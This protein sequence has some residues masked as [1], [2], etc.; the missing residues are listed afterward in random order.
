MLQAF[1]K[2]NDGN[3]KELL[4]PKL[5]ENVN[6]EVVRKMFSLAFHCAAP[7]R[8]NRPLMKEVG[9]QLWEIRKD[10]GNSLKT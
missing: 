8:A 7:T 10:F 1:G 2:F 5:Q 9:E 4:D 6:L 3:V